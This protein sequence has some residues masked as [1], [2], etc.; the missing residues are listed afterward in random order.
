[1]ENGRVDNVSFDDELRR[2]RVIPNDRDWFLDNFRR[3]SDVRG[4]REL[5]LGLRIVHDAIRH[6]QFQHDCD[7][8]VSHDGR[9]QSFGQTLNRRNGSCVGNYLREQLNL[10]MKL[11]RC[12]IDA[13]RNIIGKKG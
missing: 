11:T 2:F 6:L 1:M 10:H 7:L 3:V 9:V 4:N 13:N 5:V 8:I 12:L